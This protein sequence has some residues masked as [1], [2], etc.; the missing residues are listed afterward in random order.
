MKSTSGKKYAGEEPATEFSIFG[1]VRSRIVING[2]AYAL[3][4]R[5][6]LRRRLTEA[7]YP[8]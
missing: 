5:A 7:V 3:G 1:N 4:S 2:S 6:L 8:E